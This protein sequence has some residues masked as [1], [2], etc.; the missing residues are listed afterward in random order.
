MR[1]ILWRT[2]DTRDGY[3]ERI[4]GSLNELAVI[5]PRGL[6]GGPSAIWEAFQQYQNLPKFNSVP[7]AEYFRPELMEDTAKADMSSLSWIDVAD[8]NPENYIFHGHRGLCDVSVFPKYDGIR[9]GD[10]PLKRNRY[11]L[12]KEYIDC[13]QARAPR[14]H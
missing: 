6:N 7:L 10:H 14:Y 8:P 2:E 9:I 4:L 5:E 12:I 1:D 3:Q 11:A 13:V